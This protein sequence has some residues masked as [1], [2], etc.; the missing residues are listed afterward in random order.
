MASLA[1][2]TVQ[3]AEYLIVDNDSTDSTAKVVANFAK[4]LKSF[5]SVKRVL[6]TKLGYPVVYN[7]G[8]KT[9]RFSWV[10][11]IDDDCVAAKDWL[12]SFFDEIKLITSKQQLTALVGQSQTQAPATIWALAVLAVDQF[13]K[14]SV[15]S[16]DN[17]ILDL[18]TLDNKNI[19]YYKPF[20]LKH[21]LKFNELALKE[22]GLGAAEDAD[23]GMQIM[24][25]GGKAKYVP[26][27]LIWHR[28][29]S[30]LIWY[31]KRLKLGALGNF[32]YLKRWSKIRLKFGCVTLRA[33][34]KFRNFWPK[35]RQ[36]QALSNLNSSVILVI[37][38]L[39][40]WLINFWQFYWTRKY[41]D[42]LN[43]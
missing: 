15:V 21:K 2:Q 34:Q 30:N 10:I 9:A 6:E 7:R 26:K 3:P 35:F 19:A 4:K 43:E 41:S 11:F 31:L 29:P 8:L 37:L 1:C 42:R 16:Q 38:K 25:A 14:K 40:F 36:E 39:S 33:K 12:E 24:V 22:P 28:D 5:S 18:E 27:A 32:F 13:W 17:Y 20:L 23:L